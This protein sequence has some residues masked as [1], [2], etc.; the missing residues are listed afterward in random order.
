MLKILV[1]CLKDHTFQEIS[2]ILHIVSY[3]KRLP[4][5]RQYHN[6]FC[7]SM[8]HFRVWNI[9]QNSS[10]NSHPW[11]FSSQSEL[12]QNCTCFITN[13][14]RILLRHR[15]YL[16]S[17]FSKRNSN[18]SISSAAESLNKFLSGFWSQ[19]QLTSA[20]HSSRNVLDTLLHHFY[21]V[22]PLQRKQ[23]HGDSSVIFLETFRQEVLTE[24][25]S[26]C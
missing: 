4:I 8:E 26:S 7:A 25:L 13:K 10:L 11:D 5:F 16:R 3:L 14:F 6:S 2:F 21:C 9:F 19:Y 17:G 23:S 18:F 20:L 15:N 22:R 12:V 1:V 24:G